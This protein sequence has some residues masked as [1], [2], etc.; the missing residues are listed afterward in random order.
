MKSQTTLQGVK[1]ESD[2]EEVA[3]QPSVSCFQDRMQL[4]PFCLTL[5]EYRKLLTFS[6]NK[7]KKTTHLKRT[8]CLQ[9]Y[10]DLSFI[11]LFFCYF[12]IIL[13]FHIPCIHFSLKSSFTFSLSYVVFFVLFL[14]GSVCRICI[15]RCFMS[16][17]PFIA[18]VNFL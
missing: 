12:S 15:N 6:K 3:H 16:T 9:L 7:N 18:S 14:M 13:Y 8:K 5:S 11:R 4:T 1:V 2:R 10:S 17:F